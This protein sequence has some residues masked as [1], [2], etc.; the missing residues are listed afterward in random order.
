MVTANLH[1][2]IARSGIKINISV[3]ENKFLSL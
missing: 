2:K 3:P 1:D